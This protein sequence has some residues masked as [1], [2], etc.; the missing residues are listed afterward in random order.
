M[1]RVRLL[2]IA[3]ALL[4]AMTLTAQQATTTSAKNQA[5]VVPTPEEQLNFL[6][7]KL[8]LTTDQQEKM[9]PILQELHDA[10]LTIVQDEDI[11]KDER[12]AKVR[13]CRYKA[14]A[15]IRAILTED[16]KK[17]LDEVEAQPHPELHGNVSGAKR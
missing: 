2:T 7:P 14:D 1:N 16:Q 12:M 4:F 10:T 11:S 8:E 15:K 5:A 13:E 3:T 6:S 9:K 17:K